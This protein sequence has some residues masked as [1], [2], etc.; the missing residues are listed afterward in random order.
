MGGQAPP[1]HAAGGLMPPQ[2]PAAAGGMTPVGAGGPGWIGPGAGP[3]GAG[4]PNGGA[5]AQRRATVPPL[6]L[7]VHGDDVRRI[8][9]LPCRPIPIPPALLDWRW[10]CYFVA[11]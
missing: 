9:S 7:Q 4:G 11:L 5:G 6:S 1:P 2:Q 3:G 10:I 8:L